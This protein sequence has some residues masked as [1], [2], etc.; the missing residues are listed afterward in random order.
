MRLGSRA[1]T[2]PFLIPTTSGTA[3]LKRKKPTTA[4][5]DRGLL[6]DSFY[7]TAVLRL[8]LLKRPQKPTAANRMAACLNNKA[9]LRGQKP[10]LRH[11]RRFHSRHGIDR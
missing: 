1:A 11:D 2:S 8:N 7:A 10:R 3:P 6:N 9:A 5:R 4:F